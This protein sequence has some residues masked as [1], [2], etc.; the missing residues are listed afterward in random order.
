MSPHLRSEMWGTRWSLK[1]PTHCA[2][3]HE[4]GTRALSAQ[5]DESGGRRKECGRR[6]EFWKRNRILETGS[7]WLIW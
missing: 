2:M 5:N 3:R 4:W 7:P 1:D 6:K